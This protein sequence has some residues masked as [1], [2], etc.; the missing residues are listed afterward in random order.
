MIYILHISLYVMMYTYIHTNTEN[1]NNNNNNNSNKEEEY[2]LVTHI[3]NKPQHS[4]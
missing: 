1:V 2:A 3:Q 4:L